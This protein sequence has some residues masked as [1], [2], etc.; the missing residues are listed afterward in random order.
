MQTVT[1]IVEE[2]RE[3]SAT[4]AACSSLA[5]SPTVNKALSRLVTLVM[6]TPAQVAHEVLQQL[7]QRD[8]IPLI[9]NK[10]LEAETELEFWWSCRL[11][12]LDTLTWD[13]LTTFPYFNCYQDL[14]AL[15]MRPIERL[16]G[17]VLFVGGGSLPLSALMMAQVYNRTVTI[18]DVNREAVMAAQSLV[19]RLGLV[20][21]LPSS[22]LT[23][24]P[25]CLHSR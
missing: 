20:T 25:M 18:I 23:L 24:K 1:T 21:W 13:T 7:H 15:E 16:D 11:R 14:T 10:V 19:D 6:T 9:R 8:L 22:R 17:P 5:P 4:L 2:I 12:G 3:I